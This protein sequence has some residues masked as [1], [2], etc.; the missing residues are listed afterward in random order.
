MKDK[1]DPIYYKVKIKKLID[2]ARANGL[3]VTF[4]QK[5]LLQCLVIKDVEPTTTV[6]S[7]QLN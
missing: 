4:E 6:C 5:Y 1:K 2:E 7:V 3:E